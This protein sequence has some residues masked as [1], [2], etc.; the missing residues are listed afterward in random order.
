MVEAGEV[1]PQPGLELQKDG[2]RVERDEAAL[3]KEIAATREA[4]EKAHP[5]AKPEQPGA[6]PVRS[7]VMVRRYAFHVPETL[8]VTFDDGGTQRID[9]PVGERWHRYVFE[10]TTKI[11]S[12]QLDPDRAVLLDLNKLDDGRTREGSSLARRRWTLEFKA[13]T[14]LAFSMLESL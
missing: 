14:E 4:F 11:A 1:L 6:F 2:T 3:K 13:W 10:R 7:V 9:W 12:A 8:V 5:D